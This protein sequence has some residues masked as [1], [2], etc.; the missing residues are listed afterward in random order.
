M[1]AATHVHL[2]ERVAI[3]ILLP[4]LMCDRETVQRF[5][6]EGRAAVKIRSPHVARVKD[7]GELPDRTPYIVMEYLEGSDLGAVLEA[8]LKLPV[9]QA[10]DYVLE[11]CEAIAEAHAMKTVHRDL[12]PSN[13]FLTRMPNGTTCVK[14]LDF[15]I[16]K[17]NAGEPGAVNMTTTLAVMGSPA[18][19]SPEQLKASRT[20]DPRADIWS[21]G[22]VLHELIAGTPP[23][24]AQTIAELSVQIL[25]EDPP[26]LADVVGGVAPGL[27]GVV[28]TCLRK[29]A[30]ER[31]S[32]LADF[33]DALAPFGSTAARRSAEC[34]VHTLG[35]PA[36]RAARI[37]EPPA[38]H[39]STRSVDQFARTSAAVAP[40]A[41]A[42]TVV[43][44]SRVSGRSISAFL[45]AGIT[46]AGVGV[47]AGGYALVQRGRQANG[48]PTTSATV[49]PELPSALPAPAQIT[50]T[51]AG[52][53]PAPATSADRLGVGAGEEKTPPASSATATK[54]ANAR[55]SRP[56]S[57]VAATAPSPSATSATVA[58]AVAP[59][60]APTGTIAKSS[61]D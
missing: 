29:K 4:E 32:N 35:M 42:R 10:V 49:A 6:R 9:Q 51:S 53:P 2:H 46:L 12:K 17:M 34:I 33:A 20:V 38:A 7:V 11:A 1:L 16:S 48:V 44:P 45:F 58:T 27:A 14:V 19:M 25:S 23:F 28:A 61:K 41:A 15:G 54:S 31:F 24:A 5:L 55:P 22:V 40:S 39:V 36:V 18:Y 47:V 13:L 57:P 43:R 50:S 8:Q 52:A 60:A 21:L 37:V 56:V 3:K 26:W 30:A 59:A